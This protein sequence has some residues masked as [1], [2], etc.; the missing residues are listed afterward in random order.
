MLS[1]QGNRAMQP[2]DTR[3]N[4]VKKAYLVQTGPQWSVA[5]DGDEATECIRLFGTNILPTAFTTA[6]PEREVG[7]ALARLNPG[8][9]IVN[10]ETGHSWKVA[11]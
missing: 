9:E 8:T 10:R 5:R 3:E 1:L 4:R 11:A 7:L 2:T 6:V